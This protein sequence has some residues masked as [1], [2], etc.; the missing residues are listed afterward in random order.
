MKILVLKKKIFF[1]YRLRNFEKKSK[2]YI[3]YLSFVIF[4]IYLIT[5]DVH[6]TY[7]IKN[8]EIYYLCEY[9]KNRLC[10]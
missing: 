9:N 5:F 8:V 2:V 3:Y 10:F 6:M 1:F 4:L 7:L